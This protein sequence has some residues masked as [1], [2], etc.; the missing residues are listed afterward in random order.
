MILRRLWGKRDQSRQAERASTPPK[1]SHAQ[2]ESAIWD[3]LQQ[4]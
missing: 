2:T 4:D 1:S 3:M